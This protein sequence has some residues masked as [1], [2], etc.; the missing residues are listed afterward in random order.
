MSEKNHR[1]PERGEIQTN[2]LK[3]GVQYLIKYLPTEYGV[4]AIIIVPNRLSVQNL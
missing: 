4:R 1:N 3:Y 2:N